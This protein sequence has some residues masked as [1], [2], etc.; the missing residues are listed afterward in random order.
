MDF[1]IMRNIGLVIML[2]TIAVVLIILVSDLSVFGSLLLALAFG[3]G[4]FLFLVG[5]ELE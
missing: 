1:R 3:V 2:A 5:D 4:A